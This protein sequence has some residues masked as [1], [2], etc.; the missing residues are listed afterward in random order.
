SATNTVRIEA[1]GQTGDD[2]SV[3]DDYDGDGK[4][5][6]AV[7]RAGANSGDP[8][9]WF[10][11]GSLSNPSGN[12]TYV[13]WGQNGDFVA[14]GDYDGDGRADF[15][16][17][18]NDGITSWGRFWMFQTTAG[19]SSI[20]FGNATDRIAP[21]D[22]DGD[23]KTDLCVTQTSSGRIRWWY[24]SSLNG[25][26]N[27]VDFGISATDFTV[28]GDYDGDGKTDFAV[29]RP[30]AAAGASAFWVLGSTYG[31]Y[32]IGFGA[33]TDYPPANYNTH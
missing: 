10:Y 5:D 11:R 32:S 30:S 18:R 2:P 24:R 8:S 13:N 4:A 16:V 23:G 21:G 17:Q 33:Q 1:F 27:F 29:W 26:T 22:Y 12:V 19:F 9:T 28:Q 6:P 7:Y 25:S 14:P 15:V 3:V 31:A 20:R